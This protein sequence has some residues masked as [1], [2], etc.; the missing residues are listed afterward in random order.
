MHK[1]LYKILIRPTVTYG[2]ELLAFILFIIPTVRVIVLQYLKEE[3][4]EDRHMVLR[5]KERNS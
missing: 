3:Y 5:I 2:T 1:G 4:L